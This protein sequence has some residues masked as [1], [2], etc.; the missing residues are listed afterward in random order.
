MAYSRS[1]AFSSLVSLVFAVAAC[2]IAP[3]AIAAEPGRVVEAGPAQVSEA[4]SR[5]VSVVA[6]INGMVCGMCVQA[7]TRK[8]EDTGKVKN[9]IVDMKD[10]K[11]SFAIRLGKTF[12]DDEIRRALEGAG[13]SASRISRTE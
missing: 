8:L 5:E 12:S 13:Y 2:G 7:I 11:V 6:S 3:F 9:V 1:N 10:K 4:P